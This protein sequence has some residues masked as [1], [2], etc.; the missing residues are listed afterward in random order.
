MWQ[1]DSHSFVVTGFIFSSCE[2]FIILG[3]Q[4]FPQAVCLAACLFSECLLGN[5]MDPMEMKTDLLWD[6]F[7]SFCDYFL[8]STL[9][10][11]ATQKLR[12]SVPLPSRPSV[13]LYFH[14]FHFSMFLF[15]ALRD[16]LIFVIWVILFSSLILRVFGFFV[17]VLSQQK[18]I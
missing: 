13:L 12:R 2:F 16:L 7:G 6:I 14:H 10:V 4:V 9:F 17:V 1:L 18:N 3:L 8:P 11:P 5:W 15:C